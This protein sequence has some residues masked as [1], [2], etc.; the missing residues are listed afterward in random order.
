MIDVRVRTR[1]SDE[2]LEMKKG[3]IVTE[4]DY[5]LL[6]TGPTKIRTPENKLLCVYLPGAISED[7]LDE[8]YP[9]LHELRKLTTQ[10][11][12][13][14]GGTERVQRGAQKRTYAKPVA[15]SIIGS[16]DPGGTQRYCRLTAWT[17]QETGKFS[18]LYPL[19]Q[20]I[21]EK[22]AEY[23]PDRYATQMEYVQRTDPSWIIP[24]TPFTTVTV[25]NTY[26]TGVHQDKGD[27]DAGFSTL[28]CLRKGEYDGGVLT[29][30][31]Y[32]IG[33]NMRHGDVLLMNAHEW[34]GNTAIQPKTEDAERISIVCYYRT[35][36]VEC[37]SPE[38]ETLRAQKWREKPLEKV[39]T[40]G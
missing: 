15:S 2:E 24:K 7:V 36:M 39:S 25:N 12:G 9:T 31:Q 21:A 14:A 26:P 17:G 37:G 40:N 28:A 18:E 34:H 27:L 32:R 3:K 5:N 4:D 11:R 8:S 23:V 6:A 13:L 10:N 35:K 38:E 16:I 19:F 22:F 29:F 20:V 30:P 1:I 33:V